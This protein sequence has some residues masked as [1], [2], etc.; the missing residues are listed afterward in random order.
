MNLGCLRTIFASYSPL[1]SEA[2]LLRGLGTASLCCPATSEALLFDVGV[3]EEPEGLT[4]G[5]AVTHSL[6]R[7]ITG[8]D[9]TVAYTVWNTLSLILGLCPSNESGLVLKN[10]KL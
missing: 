4:N 9:D 6:M 2:A 10:F 1:Q 7:W 3:A 8:G 5:T